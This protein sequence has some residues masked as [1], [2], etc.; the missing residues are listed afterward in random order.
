MKPEVFFLIALGTF[1]LLRYPVRNLLQ[2]AVI[3]NDNLPRLLVV[4][5]IGIVDELAIIARLFAISAGLVAGGL[6]A[7]GYWFAS[8]K[9]D[10]GIAQVE[11][12]LSSL[13]VVRDRVTDVQMGLLLTVIGLM[14]CA[15]AYLAWRARRTAVTE[16]YRKEF[17][18]QLSNLARQAEDGGLAPLPPTADMQEIISR[19][20]TIDELSQ[21]VREDDEIGGTESEMVLDK[22][23]QNREALEEQLTMLD[24]MRRVDISAE[25]NQI[26]YAPPKGLLGRF[27]SLFVSRGTLESL[28]GTARVAMVSASLLLVPSSLAMVGASEGTTNRLAKVLSEIEGFAIELFNKES[29]ILLAK[30][31]DQFNTAP[32]DQ[33]REGDVKDDEEPRQSDL[34][35]RDWCDQDGPECDAAMLDNLARA[36]ERAYGRGV[37]IRSGYGGDG[38]TPA[39]VRSLSVRRGVFSQAIAFQSS[40]RTASTGSVFA[41]Q[42][43]PVTA[44]A[45][46]A[47]TPEEI[48]SRRAAFDHVRSVDVSARTPLREAFSSF[49][50]SEMIE[51][52]PMAWQNL[53]K[54]MS[55]NAQAFTELPTRTV[56]QE[57]LIFRALS[58]GLE[59][60]VGFG[61]DTTFIDRM[62]A[63]KAYQV[64]RQSVYPQMH[65][66]LAELM[67]SGSVEKATA[68]LVQGSA[69]QAGFRMS[70]LVELQRLRP[71][72]SGLSKNA[73][74]VLADRPGTLTK[75]D[76]AILP[77]TAN[78]F[79]KVDKFKEFAKHF[80]PKRPSIAGY[81]GFFP[82]RGDPPKPSGSSPI[83][84]GPRPGGSGGSSAA[85][86]Y[87]RMHS[88]PNVGG[89]VFGRP[90]EN[91]DIRLDFTDLRWR[92]EG[93]RIRLF[94]RRNDGVW[95]EAGPYSRQVVHL[96]LAYV[97]DGRLVPATVINSK[98][99]NDQRIGIH[100]AFEDTALGCRLLALDFYVFDQLEDDAGYR[101]V[102]NAIEEFDQIYRLA[103]IERLRGILKILEDDSG[104]FQDPEGLEK[105]LLAD[106]EHE[107]GKL[108]ESAA[109]A[110]SIRSA[111]LQ[112]MLQLPRKKTDFYDSGLVDIIDTCLKGGREFTDVKTCLRRSAA[113]KIDRNYLLNAITPL[114][115]RGTVSGVREAPW[116][117]SKDL[118]FAKHRPASSGPAIHPHHPLGPQSNLEFLIQ[119]TFD[120]PPYFRFSP[121]KRFG[122]DDDTR[123]LRSAYDED[124]WQYPMLKGIIWNAINDIADD[125]TRRDE[126][127]PVEELLLVQRLF[128]QALN[129]G[130]GE[131][132]PL[133]KLVALSRLTADAVIESATPRWNTNP[134]LKE[135]LFLRRIAQVVPATDGGSSKTAQ[136][137]NRC[138]A[139]SG[140]TAQEILAWDFGNQ[141]NPPF[142]SLVSIPQAQWE[143]DCVFAE[144]DIGDFG[145][146]D[147]LAT[148]S[149]L[150]SAA[151]V[152]RVQL[153]V[154]K[155]DNKPKLGP[156]GRGVCAP[157]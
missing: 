154:G 51:K 107:Q 83:A 5:I 122:D 133:T 130:L 156:K 105:V 27:A 72:L 16:L 149:R 140:F 50:S 135:A 80:D 106:I 3:G 146:A 92:T 82:P 102:S 47:S 99:F 49:V 142:K 37:A 69:A 4:G 148:N 87:S 9:S 2:R 48:L 147:A 76:A 12:L 121:D 120:S 53:K 34:A 67:R 22:M 129:G 104:D 150:T 41:D 71:E 15:L 68:R 54:V 42:Q 61:V 124:P 151:R 139:T 40:Q 84:S 8:A 118:E 19:I 109:L 35:S 85:Y 21:S 26:H 81:D 29:A 91:P 112:Q 57:K 86:N 11:S 131:T 44:A 7:F 113:T 18:A 137:L 75:F 1:I 138:L 23:R 155:S 115:D 24:L 39:T 125:P 38:P 10:I 144:N 111:D 97:A 100:P 127:T 141:T 64:H 152:L 43:R 62:A 128:R 55:A 89:V 123:A 46:R 110:N 20:Q 70:E 31:A 13:A 134:G 28:G 73:A 66:F 119:A 90:P 94:F 32:D 157:M 153:G 126:V 33:D 45:A 98:V 145:Y 143:R 79:R 136:T 103:R 30:Q 88:N 63:Q 65:V 114:P 25:L 52:R 36:F 14:V 60:G 6:W 96:A 108:P 93:K 117:L 78:E 56:L 95:I 101:D 59:L 132:F 74:G 17:Q 58:V 77:N 116:R